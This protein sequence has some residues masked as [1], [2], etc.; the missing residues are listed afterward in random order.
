M[1][2]RYVSDSQYFYYYSI[3]YYL[4]INSVCVCIYTGNNGALLLAIVLTVM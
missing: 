1:T 3:Y 2:A 4:Y